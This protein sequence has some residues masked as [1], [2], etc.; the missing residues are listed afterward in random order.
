MV[1]YL[2]VF[3]AVLSKGFSIYIFHAFLFSSFLNAIPLTAGYLHMTLVSFL[4]KRNEKVSS[5]GN[6]SNFYFEVA[7]SKLYQYTGHPEGIF[8]IFVNGYQQML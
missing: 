1:S 3:H 6:A 5:S 7:S 2:Y 8:V 4:Q